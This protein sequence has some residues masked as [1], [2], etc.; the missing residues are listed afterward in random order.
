MEQ[1]KKIV[2]EAPE[3]MHYTTCQGE[4]EELIV[5]LVPNSLETFQD[6]RSCS[7]SEVKEKNTGKAKYFTK[8][9]EKD[10][11]KVKNWLKEQKNAPQWAEKFLNCVQKAVKVINYDYWIANI[12]PS[13]KDG[14]IYYAKGE[15]VGVGFSSKDWEK[16]AGMYAPE[17]GSRLAELC[18][19]DMWYALR[20]ANGLWTMDYVVYNSS[21]AGNYW[22]APDSTHKMEKTGARECGGYRDGQGNSYKIVTGEDGIALVGGNYGNHGD[23]YPVADVGYDGDPNGIHNYGSGVLVFTK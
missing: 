23:N 9:T 12:E 15:D 5:R 20:I 2:L 8:I 6:N 7:Q 22:N 11:E 21:S 4:N 13:V 17:R 16:M 10:R 1:Y 3:G 18:E 14:K 19:L